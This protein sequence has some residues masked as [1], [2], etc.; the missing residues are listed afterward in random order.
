MLDSLTL[1]NWKSFGAARN[2]LTFAPLTLLVG[3][4]GSG[5]S[6]ALD[7]L[8]FL[9]GAALDYPLTD[10]LNG[11]SEGQREV[12]P[13]IRGRAIEAV[14]LAG[15]A[16]QFAVHTEWQVPHA[17]GGTLVEVSHEVTVRVQGN[18]LAQHEALQW[19]TSDCFRV[20]TPSPR[21]RLGRPDEFDDV[22]AVGLDIARRVRAT[23]RAMTFLEP[24]PARMRDYRPMSATTLGTACENVSPV[25]RS[26]GER[27]LRDVADW[28]GELC[29]PPLDRIGF[30]ETNLGEV[31]LSLNE[32]A[33]R[34][35]SAR[36][37]SDGT[38]RFLGLVTALVTA[39]EGSIIVLE[40]PDAGLHPARI[41]LLAEL[42]E[43]VTR[44]RKIQVIATTHSPTLLAFLSDEVLGNVLALGR[45]PEQ[46]HTVCSRLGDLEHFAILR[47]SDH[48]D[49]LVSTGWIERAL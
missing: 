40:E 25:L 29:A 49:R 27:E 12:W 7:A 9:Q 37:A 10:V 5:K 45:D 38:L 14:N 33:G 20:N 23:V 31:M 32:G 26:L 11:H 1:T 22:D 30:D 28:L 13:P 34:H 8:R 48:L 39:E 4:N 19:G 3:P 24:Q 16:P 41:H 36:S 2:E 42:L 18:A 35:I 17:G 43:Q 21:A 15:N 6:N 46:Q 44:D 47:E